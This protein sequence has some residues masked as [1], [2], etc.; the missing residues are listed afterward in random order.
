MGNSRRDTNRRAVLA[1]RGDYEQEDSD[2]PEDQ[3]RPAAPYCNFCSGCN[4]WLNRDL[5]RLLLAYQNQQL[6]TP[7]FAKMVSVDLESSNLAR[8][9]LWRR[10]FRRVAEGNTNITTGPLSVDDLLGIYLDQY[11]STE[12]PARSNYYCQLLLELD[13]V[14]QSRGLT[15]SQLT[16]YAGEPDKISATENGSAFYYNLNISGTNSVA[17]FETMSNHVSGFDIHFP[18]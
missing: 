8:I 12:K 16:A 13:L 11:K 4:G 6:V 5:S 2:V 10:Y 1:L 15:V 7:E 9:N 14:R 3:L 17:V 18:R